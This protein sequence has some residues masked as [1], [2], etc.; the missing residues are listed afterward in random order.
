MLAFSVD[1][2]F[3]CGMCIIIL[4]LRARSIIIIISNDV[5]M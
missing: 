4:S 3:L 5:D 2:V 1:I